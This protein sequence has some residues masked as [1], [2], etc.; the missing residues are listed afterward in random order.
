M[1]DNTLPARDATPVAVVTGIDE[2]KRG[3]RILLLA[4]FGIATSVTAAMLYAF[5]AFVIPIEKAF[6]WNRGDIQ[7]TLSFQWGGAILALLLI[8]WLNKKYGARRM[9]LL[10]L[11][12]LALGYLSF[13]AL[14]ENADISW[15]YLGYALLP[16]LGIGGMPVTWTQLVCTWFVR[17]RGL[18]LAI[19]LSGTGI[20]GAV[21]PTVITWAT[22]EWGW[23][24]GFVIMALPL[25]FVMLPLTWLWFRQSPAGDNAVSGAQDDSQVNLLAGIPFKEA[26]LTKNFWVC[27][28]ALAMVVSGVIC[29]LTSAIPLLQGKGL[30]A[31]DA[32][33]VFATYGIMLVVGRLLGGYLLDRLWAPG[34]AAVTLS[35]PALGCLILITQETSVPV[36]VLAL[37]LIG[38]GAGAEFDFSSYLLMRYFGLYDYGRLYGMHLV[39]LNIAGIA[40]PLLI[41]TLYGM[42]GDYSLM[43]QYCIAVFLLGPMLLLLLGR[44]P[45][46]E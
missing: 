30:S 46:F 40:S 42:T 39:F 32:S 15:F 43:L 14:P 31:M 44:Y 3:W 11:L 45:K 8:G 6:G 7:A 17:R 18:A 27:N 24:A 20:S 4:T 9:T 25:V 34:V 5:G 41:S 12:A 13:L 22:Q 36:L 19:V 35:L 33:R 29:V 2:F 16:V 26:L 1:T 23:R 21:L 38:M 37:G 28:L 10:S